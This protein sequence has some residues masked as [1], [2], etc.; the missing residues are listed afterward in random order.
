MLKGE[1]I[2]NR[3]PFY[4]LLGFL[5]VVCLAHF[6]YLTNSNMLPS[7]DEAHYMGGA[8]AIAQGI[9][10]GTLSGAWEGYVS[11][12]S[13][14]APLICLPAAFFMLFLPGDSFPCLLSEIPILFALGVAAYS[15][16]C[17]C[18][19]ATQ[20]A[21]GAALLTTMPMVTGLTHRFYSENL[22]LLLM[23]IYLDLLIRRGWRDFKWSALLGLVL[24]LGVLA[25]LTFALLLLLPSI[26]LLALAVRR[27]FAAPAYSS[28]IAKLALRIVMMLVLAFAL[29]WTWYCR[30]WEAV[31]RHSKVAFNCEACLYPNFQ[32]FLA[33]ISS[34]PYFFVFCLAVLGLV[35]VWRILTAR[36]T[37]D[38]VRHTWVVMWLVALV[39]LVL[40]T[41]SINKAVR[42]SE[43]WLPLIAA[44]AVLVPAKYAASLRWAHRVSLALAGLS[45]LLFLHN[46]FEILPL[47]PWRLGDLKFLDSRYPLNVPD[48]YE[49]N[50]PVDRRDYSSFSSAAAFI[51]ADAAA[52]FGPQARPTARLTVRSLLINH[53]YFSFL[54]T[55]HGYPVNYLWWA[56]TATSGLG[57][58]EY[59]LHFRN[60]RQFYPGSYFFESYPAL[61]KDVA[62]GKLSYQIIFQAPGPDN[63][64][65]LVF[66]KIPN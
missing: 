64:A 31:L 7:A 61:E 65:V 48:W 6:V 51:A 35:P 47:R 63:S 17:N 26:Y 19:P 12:L 39:S 59:I 20:A 40:T 66:R 46:A 34:G 10:T 4:Y 41:V 25:K 60:F 1:A 38:R 54:A 15:L 50:H 42:L 11:A 21:V 2:V 13:F 5:G 23:V 53:D 28:K 18:L 32:S 49:D 30:N 8:Y 52:R 9:R 43:P 44:L 57:A 29:A 24:G 36:E 37:A 33:N 55:V 27:D 16:F 3:R 62:D 56:D 45:F 58:P 22:C 14:K